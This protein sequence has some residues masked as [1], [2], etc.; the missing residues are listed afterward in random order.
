[1]KIVKISPRGYCYG[2]VDAMVIARNA[3]LDK[4]LPRPIYILGMIVHNQF[5]TDELS[6]MGIVSLDDSK[7]SK[8]ELLETI[9]DGV[10]IFTAHGI[11]DKIKNIAK[12]KG[13]ITIDATCVDVLKTKE[14][15]KEYLNND[16]DVIYFGKR[17]HPEAEAVISISNKIHLISS[18]EDIDELKI[19]ND[20]IFVTNQTT[21]SF[22]ELK[23]IF[24][25]LKNKYQNCIIQE[26]ICNAT[27]ARQKAIMD[28]KDGD[29]LYVVGD[30]KSNN[31]NKLVAIGKNNFKKV[32]LI[33]SK[34]DIN[35]KDLIGMN[36]IYISAGAS[37]PPILIDEVIDYLKSSSEF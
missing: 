12:Q 2:V 3:A 22:I 14:I 6:K 10:V 5:V 34:D 28:I 27:S 20:K 1:M 30:A 11:D 23:E 8:Q 37:T 24:G 16:Y 17:K 13:L 35:K 18:K 36:M 4:S 25:Y 26:E 31:T 19:D 15:I 21:M 29:V 33:S 9:D 7:L 32:F